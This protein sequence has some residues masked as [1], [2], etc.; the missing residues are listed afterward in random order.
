[1]VD[2]K[3]YDTG[4]NSKLQILFPFQVMRC[5]LLE[6]NAAYHQRQILLTTRDKYYLPLENGVKLLTTRDWTDTAYNRRIIL[7]TTRD[8]ILLTT[9]EWTDITYH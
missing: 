5:L 1:M 9:G 2:K 7:L 6:N 4:A 3:V 8:W